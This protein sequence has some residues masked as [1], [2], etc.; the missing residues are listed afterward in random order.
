[1]NLFQIKRSSM[2]TKSKNE[3]NEQEIQANKNSSNNIKIG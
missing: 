3:V 1:M 2:R